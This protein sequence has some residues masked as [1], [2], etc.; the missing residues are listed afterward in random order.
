MDGKEQIPADNLPELIFFEPDD[1]PE[2][3]DFIRVDDLFR[4]EPDAAAD[5][6]GPFTF[7]LF[8]RKA[9]WFIGSRMALLIRRT[10]IL[11]SVRDEFPI[12]RIRVRP[13]F[14]QWQSDP[15]ENGQTEAIVREIRTELETMYRNH[16]SPRK[17]PR[18]G[19][20]PVLFTGLKMIYRTMI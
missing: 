14:V 9:G 10:L 16:L 17:M 20:D 3:A 2:E 18:S 13:M 19:P 11:C 6:R 8:P 5:L 15:G 4:L 12:E 1:T 7:V